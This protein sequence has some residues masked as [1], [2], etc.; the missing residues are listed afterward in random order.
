[1]LDLLIRGARLADAIGGEGQDGET[2]IAIHDGRIVALRPAIALPAARVLDV[3]GC[4]VS[5]A[6]VDAHFHLDAAFSLVA[7]RWNRSGTLREGIALWSE[8]KAER[9]HERILEDALAACRQAVTQGLCAVRTH[10]DVCEPQLVATQ[11]LLEVRMRVAPF[12]D[13]QIVAFPQDGC[14]SDPSVLPR[15]ERALELGVD[16]VGGI[17]HNE[18]TREHGR[19]SLGLLLELAAH[20]GLRVDI[21]CDETDDPTSLHVLELARQTRRLHLEG[22]VAASHLCSLHSLPGAE[23]R[24]ILPRLREAELGIIANPLV[25]ITLQG[26]GDDGPIRRGMTRVKEFL[27]AGM[28]V[29]FGQDCVR[30]PW[31]CLGSHDMLEVAH[32]GLHVGQLGSEAEM[33][34]C[35]DAITTAPARILGLEGYGLREGCRADLVVLEASDVI[36]AIRER[37][38]RRW[39]IRRGQ[40]V[41]HTP[42]ATPSLLVE[43]R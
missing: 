4:L 3:H 43:I 5:P 30:D 11:A 15:I 39:V 22:R 34:A 35:F 8:I 18:S 36:S 9:D 25:N 17:P 31:Y 7:P 16:V 32:M 12:L 33:R 2:D 40:V 20:R 1:M 23:F 21:H 13:L 24:E 27:A 29:A 41:A 42:P 28:T 14:L 38:A 10:V 26:R 37:A 19:D 6:F